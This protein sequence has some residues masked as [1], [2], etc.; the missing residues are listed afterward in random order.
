MFGLMYAKDNDKSRISSYDDFLKNIDEKSKM[1]LME[2]DA[3]IQ[4]YKEEL[5]KEGFSFDECSCV[6]PNITILRNQFGFYVDESHSLDSEESY[7][8]Y[9][10][11][12]DF[13]QGFSREFNCLHR[14]L[15]EKEHIMNGNY[16]CKKSIRGDLDF[17]S[18][19]LGYGNIRIKRLYEE[20]PHHP[21]E[22]YQRL[23]ILLDVVSNNYQTNRDM[24]INECMKKLNQYL[25]PR[26]SIELKR[27]K[28][29][30]DRDFDD[31]CGIL[32]VDS[33]LGEMEMVYE[34]DG[35]SIHKRPYEKYFSQDKPYIDIYLRII[36]YCLKDELMYE[37]SDKNGLIC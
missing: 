24:I 18:A 8:L 22:E 13:Y 15:R 20:N 17:F 28:D 2:L 37:F 7:A 35:L 19:S 14:V 36:T 25:K 32:A 5:A 30:Y 4:V 33:E 11:G 29:K 16:R 27:P 3:S 9:K 34:F 21:S 26:Y 1:R 12:L 31:S 23:V 6:A 10:Y